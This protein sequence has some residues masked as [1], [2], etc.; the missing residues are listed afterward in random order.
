M[1]HRVQKNS[2]GLKSDHRSALLANMASSLIQHGRIKTTLAK[3]KALRPFVEKVITLAKKAKASQSKDALHFRRLAIAR[4]RNVAMVHKLF[5]ERVEEFIDRKGGYARIYKLGFRRG[6][7]A[8]MALIELINADDLGYEK[9]KRKVS[10]KKEKLVESTSSESKKKV[11]GDNKETLE[12][13]EGENTK[14]DKLS[15]SSS[16]DN[17]V[18]SNSLES[19]SESKPDK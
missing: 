14:T 6:D 9:P 19:T 1:R 8:E 3:A 10:S 7:A 5:D 18:E 17:T 11:E 16:S 13:F 2:L 15:G 4:L 12:P